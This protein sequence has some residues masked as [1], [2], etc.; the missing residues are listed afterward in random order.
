MFMTACLRPTY[1][2]TLFE[3]RFHALLSVGSATKAR[4]QPDSRI[5]RSTSCYF[6]A[7]SES[8]HSGVGGDGEANT[9]IH[10]YS[11]I[12]ARAS[13]SAATATT[14]LVVFLHGGGW[15]ASDRADPAG[16]YERFVTEIALRGWTS[17]NANYRIGLG[18]LENVRN[19]LCDVG[20]LVNH[21]VAADIEG[22]ASRGVVL[23]GHEAGGHLVLQAALASL[24]RDVVAYLRGVVC[25]SGIYD[26]HD[27]VTRAPYFVRHWGP[28][29][30]VRA[31]AADLRLLSPRYT[32]ADHLTCPVR[33]LHGS[34]EGDLLI[35]AQECVLALQARKV[36][37]SLRIFA[38][39][40][41]FS[42]MAPVR[43]RDEH[44]LDDICEFL[45]EC[46]STTVGRGRSQPKGARAAP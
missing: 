14:P 36:R 42:L 20:R 9:G 13:A 5:T 12:T 17:I 18:G 29:G 23:V 4:Q 25:V 22:A 19:A 39:H 28:T 7:S 26:L 21:L 6:D 46:S 31:D 44:A 33:L 34:R 38:G 1:G 32:R 11:L 40:D 10:S 16:V 27:Y 41:Q 30:M 24:P 2:R 35:Q 43:D 37:A 3:R 15:V 45:V 8:N